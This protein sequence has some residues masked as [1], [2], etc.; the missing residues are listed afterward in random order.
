M[1]GG[2]A[3]QH[4]LDVQHRSNHGCCAGDAASAFQEIQVIHGEELQGVLGILVHNIRCL[5]RVL[6]GGAKV[7]GLASHQSGAEAGTQGVH[8]PHGAFRVGFHQL[9]GGNLCCLIGS[10]D[11]GGHGEIH[12]ILP[13]FQHG[14]ESIQKQLGVE[15][16]G[17]HLAALAEHLIVFMGIKGV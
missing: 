1:P 9:P 16:A 17:L 5:P 14:A 4:R 6:S 13:P 15:Q 10:A 12:H 3:P 7:R 11:A 8:H 2:V